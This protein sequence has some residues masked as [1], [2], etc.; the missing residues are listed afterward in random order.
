MPAF[1]VSS[2]SSR[3]EAPGNRGFSSLADR[4]AAASEP[5]ANLTKNVRFSVASSFRD[6]LSIDGANVRSSPLVTATNRHSPTF[7]S[8]RCSRGQQLLFV[9]SH[10]RL[11]RLL[12]PSKRRSETA[13]FPSAGFYLTLR[14]N[15]STRPVLTVTRW[16]DR[17][18]FPR[19][20]LN[21]EGRAR[22]RCR[23]ET[24]RLWLGTRAVVRDLD[25]PCGIFLKRDNGEKRRERKE[26]DWTID[27]W[28]DRREPTRTERNKPGRGAR[29]TA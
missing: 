12:R 10:E 5:K 1:S 17:R 8:R 25:R 2:M 15:S 20:N 29:R 13:L 18:P 21:H 22:A 19:R 9:R 24:F 3:V 26:A 7:I 14:R 28:I 6:I 27:R 4:A 16:A 11:A 23:Q